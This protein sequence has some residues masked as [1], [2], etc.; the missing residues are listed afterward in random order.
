M[1]IYVRSDSF[2]LPFAVT[3]LSEASTVFARW[4]IRIP[5]GAWMFMCV[6]SVYVVLVVLCVGSG[7][8]TGWTPVQRVLLTNGQGPTKGCRARDF[9]TIHCQHWT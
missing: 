4:N 7:L 8:A 9:P 2:L 6:Y 5:P 1:R 3:A